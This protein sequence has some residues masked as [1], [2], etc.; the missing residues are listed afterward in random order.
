MPI[1]RPR[2]TLRW[3]M[4][5]VALVAIGAWSW[6]LVTLR[7]QEY[8]RLAKWHFSNVLITASEAM[9]CRLA[10]DG[11]Q[12]DLEEAKARL[13]RLEQKMAYHQRLL[14]KYER[15]AARPWIPLE[16]DPPMPRSD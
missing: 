9:P 13:A 12:G 4:A 16:P 8:Q 7:E 2:F 6:R 15:A 1:L 14:A 11:G 5:V 10:I 3:L